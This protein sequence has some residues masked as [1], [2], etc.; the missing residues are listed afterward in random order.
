M[1][2]IT[3][4][5]LSRPYTYEVSDEELPTLK[6]AAE[7]INVRAAEVAGNA[8]SL[9]TE[10]IAVSAALQIAFDALRG[11]LSRVPA[12]PATITRV[13]T[14]RMK[15]DEALHPALEG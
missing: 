2:Q 10:R 13:A 1:S 8:K 4:T 15:I 9:T 6:A 11:N 3:L 12:D 7:L 14:L 5:I